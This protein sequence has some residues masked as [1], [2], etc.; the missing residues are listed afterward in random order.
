M[1]E[2][3]ACQSRICLPQRQRLKS[4]PKYGGLGKTMTV[5][6][7]EIAV[8][9]CIKE[10]DRQQI[11][12]RSI[13]IHS[14]SQAVTKVLDFAQPGYRDPK[15]TK[16]VGKGLRHSV[17][18]AYVVVKETTEELNDKRSQNWW[19]SIPSQRLTKKF[20][21]GYRPTFTADLLSR[22][23]KFVRTIVG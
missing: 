22:D 13:D 1:E 21:V 16:L 23:R 9:G 18:I 2:R 3:L 4:E 7:A 17:G 15:T 8:L 11:N 14:D 12:Y 5:F 6:Q 10:L 20:L 19:K